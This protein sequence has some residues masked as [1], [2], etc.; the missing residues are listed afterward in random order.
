M[1]QVGKLKDLKS[2]SNRKR[3][4]GVKKDPFNTRANNGN[5]SSTGG[6]G[7]DGAGNN[8]PE[9]QAADSDDEYQSQ[10]FKT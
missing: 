3:A 1:S 7:M 9:K 4:T 2:A 10:F 6:S 8:E 5:V